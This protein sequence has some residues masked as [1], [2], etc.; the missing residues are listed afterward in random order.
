M[1]NG[2]RGHVA[3][4]L[5][6]LYLRS[7]RGWKSTLVQIVLPAIITFC[8]QSPGLTVPYRTIDHSVEVFNASSL[9]DPVALYASVASNNSV[10]FP[11]NGALLV[12]IGRIR[13]GAASLQPPSLG[14]PPRSR[15]AT[16]V[17]TLK[18]L[19]H[20][21]LATMTSSRKFC[22]ARHHHQVTSTSTTSP[23]TGRGHRCCCGRQT[24]TPRPLRPSPT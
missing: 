7:M 3:L 2:A 10:I 4:M 21:H 15:V 24:R 1:G 9:L 12:G 14:Q 6:R 23:S 18:P 20:L 16:D 5:W 19:T 11:P 13:A 22:N 8:F 17:C